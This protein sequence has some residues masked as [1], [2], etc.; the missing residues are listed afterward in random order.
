MMLKI[1]FY[2]P[3]INYSLKYIKMENSFLK[4]YIYIYIYALLYTQCFLVFPNWRT[5]QNDSSTV[6]KTVEFENVNGHLQL[7][8]SHNVTTI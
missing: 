1:K 7:I 6:D 5:N 2:I 3:E 8:S 4:L